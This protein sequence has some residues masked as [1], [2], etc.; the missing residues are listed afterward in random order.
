MSLKIVL[1]GSLVDI[2]GRSE[3]AI[4]DCKDT[5]ELK[6]R[7]IIDFPKLKSCEFLISVDKKIIRDNLVFSGGNEI[8]FLPPF[9]GG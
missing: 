1:F 9:S 3:I 7:M 2:I 5:Q 8:A 4:D 6:E